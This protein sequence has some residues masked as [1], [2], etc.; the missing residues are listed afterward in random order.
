MPSE[1]H[2][3]GIMGRRG[4]TRLKDFLVHKN[5]VSLSALL[6]FTFHL[7]QTLVQQVGSGW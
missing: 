3:H 6:L 4:L 7:V 5:A 2:L 1:H